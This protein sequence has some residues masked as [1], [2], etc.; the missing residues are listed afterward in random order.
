M[1]RHREGVGSALG[2]DGGTECPQREVWP[3]GIRTNLWKPHGASVFCV[4]FFACSPTRSPTCLKHSRCEH[5]SK[6]HLSRKTHFAALKP[7]MRESRFLHSPRFLLGAGK[8][9]VGVTHQCSLL[10]QSGPW[11]QSLRSKP[12]KV[13]RSVSDRQAIM[14]CSR[15]WS[16]GMNLSC[17]RRRWSCGSG[18]RRTSPLPSSAVMARLMLFLRWPE[19]SQMSAAEMPSLKYRKMSERISGRVSPCVA[20]MARN[21]GSRYELIMYPSL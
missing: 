6:R 16:A 9:L 5:S 11:A 21:E 3:G 19:K 18:S 13:L 15:C 2:P 8:S 17:R 1:R 4:R 7:Y 14:S 10:F 20:S 12:S